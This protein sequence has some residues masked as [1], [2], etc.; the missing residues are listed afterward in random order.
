MLGDCQSLF[1]DT[2]QLNA[3][4]SKNWDGGGGGLLFIHVTLV[5]YLKRR[6]QLITIIKPINTM[7]LFSKK[8]LMKEIKKNSIR[9]LPL[10]GN[11]C[12]IN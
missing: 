9:L 11:V 3:T 2:L 7:N 6:D 5:V 4:H 12:L 8:N 1:K 10:D